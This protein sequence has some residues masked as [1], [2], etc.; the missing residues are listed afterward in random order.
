[1]EITINS[2]VMS[3]LGDRSELRPHEKRYSVVKVDTWKAPDDDDFAYKVGEIDSLDEGP[4]TT[5]G[6]GESIL[7]LNEA[8]NSV[9]ATNGPDHPSATTIRDEC[10]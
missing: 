7:I 5:A 1:M 3:K 8:G 2:S 6:H 9:S 10:E 4:L